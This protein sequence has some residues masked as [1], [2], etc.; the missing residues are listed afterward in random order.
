MHFLG[1]LTGNK[2]GVNG[3]VLA[4]TDPL[5]TISAQTPDERVGWGDRCRMWAPPQQLEKMILKW[6][7]EMRPGSIIDPHS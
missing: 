7:Y 6:G 2:R 5:D 3:A 1:I 4:G